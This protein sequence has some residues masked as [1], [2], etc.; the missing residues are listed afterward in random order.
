MSFMDKFINGTVFWFKWSILIGFVFF[1]SWIGVGIFDSTYGVLQ[2]RAE[3]NEIYYWA[4]ISAPVI[5]GVF[6]FL[7]SIFYVPARFFF[8]GYK[9]MIEK[10]PSCKVTYGYRECPNCKGSKFQDNQCMQCG[11]TFYGGDIECDECGTVGMKFRAARYFEFD[12]ES[13]D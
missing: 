4:I 5:A 10:C 7:W 8:I 2:L 9:F 13:K 3:G 12:D 11:H 6:W 1:A